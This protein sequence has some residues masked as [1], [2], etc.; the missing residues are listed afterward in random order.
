MTRADIPIDELFIAALDGRLLD[1]HTQMRGKVVSYDESAKTCEVEL[2]VRRALPDGDGGYTFEDLPNI[3][4]VPV[5]WVGAGG[6][7]FHL[8]LAAGDTVW[9]SFDEVDAQQWETSGQ[10]SNP[11]WIERF[12]LSSVLAHPYTRA[13]PTTNGAQ[14]VCPSPFVFG[15]AAAA[16]FA[17]LSNLVDANF[18]A[19]AGA[20][21]AWAVT[22]NDGG[23]ALKLLVAALSFSPTAATK[24][25]A[26]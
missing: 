16:Q 7:F 21:S 19:L 18:A 6:F 12:G 9:L 25:K 3:P 26:Q 4:H 22:P 23:A 14:M 15:D 2:G 11:G 5:A 24:L 8:P 17:A 1:V 10:P 20:F 13:P